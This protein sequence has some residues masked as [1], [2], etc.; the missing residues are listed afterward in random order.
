MSAFFPAFFLLMVS[1]GI[2]RRNNLQSHY[3][4]IR[5]RRKENRDMD[6]S[7]L[8]KYIGKEC[9]ISANGY[10]S[11]LVG[12][13]TEVSGNWLS[14]EDKKGKLTTFNCDYISSIKER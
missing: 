9:I 1:F 11:G 13:V 3:M 14:I 8:T 10:V 12:K 4:K 7:L 2:L 5:K 6:N